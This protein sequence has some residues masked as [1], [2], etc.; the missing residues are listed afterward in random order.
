MSEKKLITGI[1]LKYRLG[2]V[3]LWS[4]TEYSPSE[5]Q[6]KFLSSAR[7]QLAHFSSYTLEVLFRSAT[8]DPLVMLYE[9]SKDHSHLVAGYY[10]NNLTPK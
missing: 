8:W 3:A 9:K 2:S 6:G 1:V 7:R 5:G 4:V 10:H